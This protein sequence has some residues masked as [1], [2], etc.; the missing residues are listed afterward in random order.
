M[1]SIEPCNIVDFED[2][3]DDATKGPGSNNPTASE[4]SGAPVGDSPPVFEKGKGPVDVDESPKPPG[5]SPITL[6]GCG[7]VDQQDQGGESHQGDDCQDE[8]RN[9]VW[10][11]E[12][13]ASGKESARN[14]LDKDEVPDGVAA[15]VL[16]Q[17]SEVDGV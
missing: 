15:F 13:Y 7:M 5:F 12:I 16:E 3:D 11:Y 6:L 4:G 17:F 1:A 9:V 10:Y 8:E 14:D 2:L